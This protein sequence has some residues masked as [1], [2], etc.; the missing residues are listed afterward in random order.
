MTTL[1]KQIRSSKIVELNHLHQTSM[2]V[3]P[4]HPKFTRADNETY[5]AGD[6]N[7][8]CQIIMGDHCGTHVDAPSHFIEGG[9]TIED[10]DVSQLMGRGLLLDMRHIAP[11]HTFGVKNIQ[12][13]ERDFGAIEA[14][15]IVI[16]RTGWHEKWALK[17]D[18]SAFLQDWPGLS[19]EGAAYL[20][21]KG[22]KVFG[23]DALSLDAFG[24]AENPAHL[25]VL[26]NDKL[27]I[28]N[29]TNLQ[30]LPTHFCFIALPLRIEHGSASPVRAIALIEN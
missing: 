16:F 10:I 2:P 28:E 9:K 5:A 27:I 1:W 29:L 19:A 25:A 11:C 12:L 4:T 21:A 24:N 18:H 30:M 6:G 26:G 17:P 23:T 8:N 15:D 13:W 14:D 20:I 22:V 7:Y 3:W